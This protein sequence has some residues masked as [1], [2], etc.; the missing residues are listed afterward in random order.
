MDN[1]SPCHVLHQ[2]SS[3]CV[4]VHTKHVC[5]QGSQIRLAGYEALVRKDI[6]LKCYAAA[7]HSR[8]SGSNAK[9]RENREKRHRT[10]PTRPTVTYSQL[11]HCSFFV[12]FL[13]P[14]LFPATC[15]LAFCPTV[16]WLDLNL[17]CVVHFSYSLFLHLS[18]PHFLN[19]GNRFS[20][21][22]YLL[23][24]VGGDVALPV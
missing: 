23:L 2:S 22:F 7:M 18:F 1:P 3:V 4:C 21:P 12:W 5:R 6:W 20:E 14:V 15:C 13:F 10:K 24:Q 9:E 16:F 17:R 11:L 8:I 19:R